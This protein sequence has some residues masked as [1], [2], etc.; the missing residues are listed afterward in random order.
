M[1]DRARSACISCH[2]L[3]VRCVDT[4]GSCARCLQINVPCRY[5]SS[6]AHNAIQPRTR[7]PS[8]RKARGPYKKGKTPREKEL[9]DI[10]RTMTTRCEELELHLQSS[11]K[12]PQ[13]LKARIGDPGINGPQIVFSGSGLPISQQQLLG[14]W[15]TYMTRVEPLV[16][17]LPHSSLNDL[18]L[19]SD[20]EPLKINLGGQTLIT[21]VCLAAI[22][23]LSENETA[24]QF[25]RDKDTLRALLTSKMG[26]ILAFP[27]TLEHPTTRLLQGLVLHAVSFPLLIA[28]QRD[29]IKEV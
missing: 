26:D 13:N 14:L 9:E 15:H 17:L 27:D 2:R 5:P 16:K 18:S 25:N 19:L 8:K 10:L 23:A 22:N 12:I 11:L 21:S 3:K 6:S 1:Q 20:Q 29:D 28:Y 7:E 4:G 24:Q